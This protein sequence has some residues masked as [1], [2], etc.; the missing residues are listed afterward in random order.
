MLPPAPVQCC[1][2]ERIHSASLLISPQQTSIA[3]WPVY[4]QERASAAA[5]N[6]L[7]RRPGRHGDILSGNDSAEMIALNCSD[8]QGVGDRALS[9]EDRSAQNSFIYTQSGQDE[10]AE[11]RETRVVPAQPSLGPPSAAGRS[12]HDERARAALECRFDIRLALFSLLMHGS[13]QVMS[14]LAWSS[15]PGSERFQRLL[16]I[17]TAV[18]P[19]LLPLR[20]P[21]LYLR[22]RSEVF[23]VY[24]V[25][26]FA[27]PLLR[28][29]AGGCLAGAQW[30]QARARLAA[31]GCSPSFPCRT[32]CHP[33]PC[34]H[35][36]CAG[37]AAT[38]R[39][40][41]AAEGPVEGH[42]G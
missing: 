14:L 17:G 11:A 40:S 36:A 34:R 21:V 1:R 32:S 29:P 24:R 35:T 13:T 27:F 19:V 23:L 33:G 15:L 26:F 9:R 8:A 39:C 12:S 3:S 30:R 16:S 38:A 22:W 5:M 4:P 25:V 10:D 31:A 2:E 41:R 37:C 42:L 28:K 18:V 6:G 20:L 7:Q